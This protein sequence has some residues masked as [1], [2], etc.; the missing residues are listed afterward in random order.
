MVLL[1]GDV[2]LAELPLTDRAGTKVRPALVVQNDLNNRRLQDVILA[3]VTSTMH[4]VKQA[5]TQLLIELASPD[6]R[7]SGLLRDSAVKCEHLVTLHQ[8]FVRRVIG[9][10]SVNLMRQIDDCLKV[11]LGL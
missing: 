1:R 9:H 4:R 10:L 7:Q 5:P 6:G 11:S 8:G 2:V 3:L